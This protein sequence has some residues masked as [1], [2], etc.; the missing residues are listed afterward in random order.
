MSKTAADAPLRSARVRQGPAGTL[1]PKRRVPL[2]IGGLLLVLLCAGVFAVTQMSRD[3]TVAVLA[4]ARP[5]PAGQPLTE[6]DL[7]TAYVVPDPGVALVRAADIA[8]VI[9]RSPAVPLAEGTLL[10]QSQLGPPA[11]P[12]SGQAVVAVAVKP[13]RAPA[14][15][16]PGAAVR[17]VTVDK[18]TA[19]TAPSP[20]AAPVAATVTEVS[21]TVDGTG[22]RVVSLL[23]S[24]ADATR[25]AAEGS[26]LALVLVGRA[27]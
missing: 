23:L 7:R 2:L 21:S 16:A 20:A 6:S 9:G 11:F 22:T 25:I 18:D 24:E 3:A 12:P 8:Q 13:G 1:A 17:V 5:V 10:G 26:E 4:V 14:G 27:L 15:L 19:T